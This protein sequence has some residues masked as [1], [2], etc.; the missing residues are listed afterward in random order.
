[1]TRAGA[2]VSAFVHDVLRVASEAVATRRQLHRRPEL[3]FAE[4]ET[5]ALIAARCRR[6]GLDVRTG[7]GGTGV[8]ADIRGE[9]PGPTTVVRA[10]MDALPVDEIDDGR[11]YRSTVPGVS[12]ACGHD[13]HVAIALAVAELMA[14]RRTWPG[15]VRF[16]FQPAEET[17]E[18]AARLIEAGAL[19]GVDHAVGLHVMTDRPTGTVGLGDG[20]QWAASDEVDVAVT[21]AGGHA[22]RPDDVADPLLAAAELVLVAHRLSSGGSGNVVVAFGSMSSG[23]TRNVISESASL[24]GTLR[25]FTPVERSAAMDDLREASGRIARETGTRIRLDFGRHCP[26]LVGD[27]NVTRVVRESLTDGSGRIT[28]EG[29]APIPGSDDMACFLERVPGCYLRVG[30]GG[31]RPDQASR[32]HSPAFDIDEGAIP[33][34]I[35]ALLCATMATLYLGSDQR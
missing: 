15:R 23:T 24:S 4:H 26:A 18:G 33:V 1:M 16:C 13:A 17:D 6:L 8:L 20:V 2:D 3:A 27:A 9:R 22:S 30:A 28:I 7:V 32:H 19:D 5:A 12:H 35:E 25:S 31:A 14:E 29:T 11:P 21:G 10:D 34:G